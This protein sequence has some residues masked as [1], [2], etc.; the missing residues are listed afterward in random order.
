MRA[1]SLPWRFLC[2]V[3]LRTV[4]HRLIMY[5]GTVEETGGA[6]AVVSRELNDDTSV[7]QNSIIRSD[8]F[9]SRGASPEM[10]EAERQVHFKPGTILF[11]R[12]DTF[13]RGTPVVEGRCRRIHSIVTPTTTP[14]LWTAFA[15]FHSP[16]E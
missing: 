8:G 7:V 14:K 15:P 10:Y 9:G 3:W 1:H 4:A 12:F 2:S 13:H 5:L 11:Y 16:Y 6:T